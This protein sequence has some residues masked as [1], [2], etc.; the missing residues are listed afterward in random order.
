MKDLEIFENEWKVPYRNQMISYV[1]DE[2]LAVDASVYLSSTRNKVRL[3]F[4]QKGKTSTKV[5]L[6]TV[7]FFSAGFKDFYDIYFAPLEEKGVN[8]HYDLE[9]RKLIKTMDPNHEFKEEPKPKEE[10]YVA[11]KIDKV[12]YILT[13]MILDLLVVGL[14]LLELLKPF[15]NDKSLAAGDIS[16]MITLGIVFVAIPVIM[17]ISYY[18]K[19]KTLRK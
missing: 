4:R 19:K 10:I 5:E 18:K 8:I 14:F 6:D 12:P 15:S 1:L 13:I 9:I 3:S 17:I 7:D 2:T 11:P 16:M